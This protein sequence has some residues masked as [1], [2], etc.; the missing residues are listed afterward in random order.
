MRHPFQK[1][2]PDLFRLLCVQSVREHADDEPVVWP[3]VRL[4]SPLVVE[5]M[6]PVKAHELADQASIGIIRRRFDREVGDAEELG[7][8]VKTQCQL[9]HHPKAAA[10]AAF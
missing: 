8:I 9:T 4:L 1:R 2:L 6:L 3:H 7:K 5:E 10:S